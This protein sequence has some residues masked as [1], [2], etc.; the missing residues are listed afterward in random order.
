MLGIVFIGCVESSYILLSNLLK[1]GAHVSGVITMRSSTFNADFKSLEP[2]AAQ[3]KIDCLCTQD[4]NDASTIDFILNKKPDVIYCFGWSKLISQRILDIP[5][6]GVVGF[7][8]AALPS[9][10]G[11]HP[12]IWALALGMKKIASTFFIMDA[13]A[14]RGDIIIQAEIDIQ[15]EDN[16]ATLYTKVLDAAIMQMLAFTDGFRDGTI[17]KSQQNKNEGNTWR[18]R[19]RFDGQIDW[20]MST[21]AIY[22]LVRA[23][24]H[25]YVGAHFIF[26][27]REI[28]VWRCE[29]VKTS[30]YVNIEPGKVIKVNTDMDYFVKAYDGVIHVLLSD[31][32][33]LSEGEY[34]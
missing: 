11:R 20:R 7:H 24:T 33:N 13:G 8:P 32:V 10:K 5:P 21:E 16:A 19:N 3:Y 31:S 28:K 6:M 18:K 9:N 34:L 30:D 26:N 29:E 23:L 1:S 27:N 17:M 2:L 4:I 12:I 14:D 15:Y 22:N 25:P